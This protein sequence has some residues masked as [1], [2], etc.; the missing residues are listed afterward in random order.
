V[1]QHRFGARDSRKTGRSA[2]V[3]EW[4]RSSAQE[5]VVQTPYID[6]FARNR[7][8]EQRKRATD[9]DA[10]GDADLDEMTKGFGLGSRSEID[11]PIRP[12]QSTS[13]SDKADRGVL[14]HLRTEFPDPSYRDSERRRQ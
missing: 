1:Q 4:I 8:I 2:G 9:G 10:D 11:P 7:L 13:R 6:A 12:L 3:S 5:A 14:E